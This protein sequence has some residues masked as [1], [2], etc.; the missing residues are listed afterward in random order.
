MEGSLFLFSNL[1]KCIIKNTDFWQQL[2]MCSGQILCTPL[3]AILFIL[4]DILGSRYKVYGN[5]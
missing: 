4:I 2:V 5:F 3:F 1:L